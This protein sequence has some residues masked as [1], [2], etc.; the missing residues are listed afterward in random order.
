MNK[1]L[2]T[3]ISVGLLALLP[4]LTF[5]VPA[6]APAQELTIDRVFA[7]LK[8]LIN[9]IFALLLV[10]STFFIFYAAY[11][12]LTAAGDPEKVKSANNQLIY[13]AVAIAVAFV[14]QG[15]QVLVKQL[16]GQ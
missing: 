6:D 8:Q 2:K 11:L 1:N 10:V 15:I 9:W 12:Y 13:A 16:L 4:L 14:A 3:T 5:A 7:I